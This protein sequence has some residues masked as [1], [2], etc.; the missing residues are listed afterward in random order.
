MMAN[1]SVLLF[2]WECQVQEI[3]LFDQQVQLYMYTTNGK[4]QNIQCYIAVIRFPSI[5]EQ[6]FLTPTDFRICLIFTMNPSFINKG[7]NNK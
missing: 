4:L 3:N 6:F 1:A 7:M 5:S 2:L